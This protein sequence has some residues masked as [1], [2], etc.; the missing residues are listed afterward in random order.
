MLLSLQVIQMRLTK[1]E[2]QVMEV[3]WNSE[4]PLAASAIKEQFK[5]DVSIYT[6]QQV[7]QR[8]LTKKYIK[9]ERIVQQG[10]TL[11]REYTPLI[12]QAE[13]IQMFIN[14]KT[15]F[16]LATH[17]VNESNDLE[18]IL[19]LEKMIEEKIKNLK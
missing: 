6:I 3:L 4:Q 14:M 9:V 8:L 2:D 19:Q 17:F 15:N 13:H 16:D 1:R 18:S 10:K 7:L 5:E 11:M 12:S